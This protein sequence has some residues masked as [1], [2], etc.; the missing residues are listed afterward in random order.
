[1]FFTKVRLYDKICLPSVSSHWSYEPQN[2]HHRVTNSLCHLTNYTT[3]EAFSLSCAVQWS[4]LLLLR[5]LR[6]D[7]YSVFMVEKSVRGSKH[8]VKANI[9]T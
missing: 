1:V 4:G 5:S 3:R 8:P 2:S 9:M 6:W 7:L